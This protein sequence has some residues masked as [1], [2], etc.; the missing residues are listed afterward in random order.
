METAI[1]RKRRLRYLRNWRKTHEAHSKEWRRMHKKELISYSTQWSQDNPER[2][3]KNKRKYYKKHK[4]EIK[5]KCSEYHR[6]H[7]DAVLKR[8]KEYRKRNP[9]KFIEN[10]VN[11]IYGITLK[12][13]NTKLRSQN[14]E[15]AICHCSIGV[16]NGAK[17]A[18]DHDHKTGKL[19]EFLCS[20]CNTA[21]GL[22]RDSILTLESAIKYLKRHLK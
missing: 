12:E 3:A 6:I 14:N 2:A 16:K 7:R 1:A 18:L 17:K 5:K 19:R 20:N 4:E 22:F 15:C 8:Q 9:L 21:L 11:R 10:Y 13:Y